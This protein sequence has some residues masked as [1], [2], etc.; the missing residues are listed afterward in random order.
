[1]LLVV[2]GTWIQIEVGA[3]RLPHAPIQTWNIRGPPVGRKLATPFLSFT[4]CNLKI[5]SSLGVVAFILFLHLSTVAQK[6]PR[7]PPFT[8]KKASFCD[9]S[10]KVVLAFLTLLSFKTFSPS[11]AVLWTVDPLRSYLACI[12]I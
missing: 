11:F 9:P 5:E 1:M 4:D 6:P 10:L 3:E 7:F 2:H 8:F 12:G